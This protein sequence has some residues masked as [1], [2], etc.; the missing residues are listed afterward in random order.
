MT[1][2]VVA[3]AVVAVALAVK[4]NVRMRITKRQLK[5]IIKEEKLKLLKEAPRYGEQYNDV[6]EE[7]YVNRSLDQLEA[8]DDLTACIERCRAMGIPDRDIADTI[9]A[10]GF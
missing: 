7:L 3:V 10:G 9:R 5:R 4:G 6:D 8:L 2:I 1:V